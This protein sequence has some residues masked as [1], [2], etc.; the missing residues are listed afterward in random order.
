MFSFSF[1]VEVCRWL[2]TYHCD[3]STNTTVSS[4]NE[5]IVTWCLLAMS[6]GSAVYKQPWPKHWSLW[7]WV[8]YMHN[9]RHQTTV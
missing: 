8:Q 9:W 7:Y 6:S 3:Y 5:C 1:T 4:A 2:T